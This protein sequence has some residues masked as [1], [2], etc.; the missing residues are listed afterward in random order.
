MFPIFAYKIG[1]VDFD[2]FKV[3]EA[4]VP[5]SGSFQLLF[6]GTNTSAI[7]YGATAQEVLSLCLPNC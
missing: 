4:S 7:Q 3:Q 6:S 2:F 1:V 5:V